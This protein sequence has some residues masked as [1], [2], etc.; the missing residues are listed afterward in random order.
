M[1]KKLVSAAIAL[2]LFGM[3]SV[4]CAQGWGWGHP[5]G[6]AFSERGYGPGYG[7]HGRGWGRGWGDRAEGPP[8]RGGYGPG[9]GWHGRGWGHHRGYG[10][11]GEMPPWCP[12]SRSADYPL[13]SQE[14]EE[15]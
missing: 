14:V 15:L 5:P 6:N 7:W 1:M 11:R 3:I 8:A 12:W 4:G 10:W 9:H 13:E 2:V